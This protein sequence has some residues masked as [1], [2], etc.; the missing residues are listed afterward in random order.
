MGRESLLHLVDLCLGIGTSVMYIHVWTNKLKSFLLHVFLL[1][2][3][4]AEQGVLQMQFQCQ[5]AEVGG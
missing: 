2:H 1:G 4:W 3:V 5:E